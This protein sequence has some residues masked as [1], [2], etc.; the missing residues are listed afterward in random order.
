MALLYW[1][2]G[3]AKQS[4][5]PLRLAPGPHRCHSKIL[6][7]KYVLRKEKTILK[8][9]LLKISYQHFPKFI[10]C[11]TALSKYLQITMTL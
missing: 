10:K 1:S 4:A 3:S 8:T 2:C 9:G 7:S 5:D 6:G 11:S